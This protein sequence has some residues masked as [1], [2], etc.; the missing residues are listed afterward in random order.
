MSG[1]DKEFGDRNQDIGRHVEIDKTTVRA[2]GHWA[3]YG[4]EAWSEML[5][6]ENLERALVSGDDGRAQEIG[7]ELSDKARSHGYKCADVSM[8]ATAISDDGITMNMDRSGFPDGADDYID[9]ERCVRLSVERLAKSPNIIAQR[10]IWLRE[11]L[12]RQIDNA[13]GDGWSARE[14]TEPNAPGP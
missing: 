2:H 3:R 1:T 7:N 5:T 4:Y 9:Y 13:L 14:K 11:T 12:W 8:K 6:W 10:K